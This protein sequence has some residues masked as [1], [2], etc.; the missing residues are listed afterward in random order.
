MKVRLIV[1][2]CDM[3]NSEIINIYG[4][5]IA[6]IA[7]GFTAT[8]GI[9][10]WKDKTGKLVVEPVTVFDCHVVPDGEVCGR[11]YRLAKAIAKDLRQDCV[12]LEIDGIVEL[13]KL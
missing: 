11:F 6:T 10:G 7:G 9:G 1:P 5:R 4:P 12:Y 3:V 8:Q 2:N 13:V